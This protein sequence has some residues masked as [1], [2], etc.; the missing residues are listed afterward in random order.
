[1]AASAPYTWVSNRKA[2]ERQRQGPQHL[3]PSAATREQSLV[4]KLHPADRLTPQRPDL[5]H[6]AVL[7]ARVDGKIGA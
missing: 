4:Q 3:N 2:E 7:A 1:M 5:G 6:M